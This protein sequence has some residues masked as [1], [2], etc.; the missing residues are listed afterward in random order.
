MRSKYEL[1]KNDIK[2]CTGDY[3]D[4]IMRVRGSDFSYVLLDEKLYKEKQQHSLFYDLSYK[5]STGAKP[6]SIRL[7][8]ID[9]LIKIHDGIRYLVLFCCSYCDETCDRIK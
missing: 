3:F 4:D 6:L 1:K 9:G 5:T 7:N 8:K 2:N